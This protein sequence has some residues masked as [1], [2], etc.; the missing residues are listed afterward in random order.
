MPK[1]TQPWEARMDAFEERMR[2]VWEATQKEMA[3]AQ[4]VHLERMASIDRRLDATSK[5]LRYG[6]KLLVQVQE[7]QKQLVENLVHP[8]NGGKK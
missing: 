1:R 6:A 8:R 7:S 5:L 4:K 3:A 2:G